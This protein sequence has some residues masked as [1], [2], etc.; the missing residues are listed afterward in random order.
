MSLLDEYSSR[1]V[2]LVKTT[3]PDGEGGDSITWS[4]GITFTAAISYLTASWTRFQDGSI[5]RY[6]ILTDKSVVLKADD[7]IRRSDGKLFRVTSDGDDL[8]TPATSGLNKRAVTAEE[9]TAL[10]GRVDDE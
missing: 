10:P 1:C 3:E 6:T 7:Y 5:S 8:F 4:D 2:L 9:V